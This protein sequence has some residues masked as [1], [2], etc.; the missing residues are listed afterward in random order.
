M[1][2]KIAFTEKLSWTRVGL[3]HLSLQRLGYTSGECD[4]LSDDQLVLVHRG[5]LHDPVGFRW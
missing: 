2:S 3:T 5:N 1:L 4:L